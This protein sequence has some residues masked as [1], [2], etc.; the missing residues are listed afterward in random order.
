MSPARPPPASEAQPAWVLTLERKY[1]LAPWFTRALND[2]RQWK[3]WVR[4]MISTFACMVLMLAQPS[5]N[6]LGAAAFFCPLVSQMLPPYLA[7]SIYVFAMITLIIGLLFG[8]AWGNAAMAAALRARSPALYQRQMAAAQAGWVP[9]VSPI[10]Q[11]E[12]N[13]IHGDFLDPRSSAVYGV[14]IFVGGYFLGWLRATR[15]RLTLAAIFATIIMDLVCTIG[16]LF[17][18][19]QYLL[20]KELVVPAACFIAIALA[21]IVLILPQTLNHIILDGL[22][23][24]LLGP[25]ISIIQIQNQLLDGDASEAEGF[26][27]AVAGSGAGNG[28]AEGKST[29]NASGGLTDEKRWHELAEKTFNLRKK[30]VL[31]SMELSAQTGMLQLEI[32]RGQIGP[33]DLQ[34]VFNKVK[35]LGARVYGLTSFVLLVEEQNRSSERYKN[36]PLPH[37]AL[38][39]K[40]HIG[41]ITRYT[42]PEHS[43]ANLLPVLATCTS[44]LRQACTRSLNDLSSWFFLVNHTR[45]KRVPKD[46]APIAE[47]EE[48][49]AEVRRTL[50][51][52]R[53][54]RQFALI[55]QFRDSFDLETGELKSDLIQAHRY[56]TRELSR[57]CVLIANLISFAV[58][59]IELL[60][61]QL[62]IERR[63]PK[64]KIQWPNAFAKMLVK[65]ANDKNGGGNPVDMGLKDTNGVAGGDD[66]G[67]VEDE[68]EEESSIAGSSNAKKAKEK[69][70]KEKKEKKNKVYAKDPD[71]GPP[72]NTFQRFGRATS[73]FGKALTG[74]SGLFAFKHALV[75]VALYIP[76]VCPSSAWIYFTNRGLWGLI[77]AQT[78]MGVFTGEQIISFI[79]RMGATIGGA[80]I[81]MVV[82]Y[83]GSGRGNGNP[84][85]VG[86]ATMVFIA[87]T[88]FV[89]IVAPMAQSV[90]WIMLNVTTMFVV[91]YSWVDEHIEQ[92][93]NQGHGA[94]LAGRRALLVIIGFAAAFLAMLFP[95]PTSAKLVFRHRLAKNIADIGDLYGKVITGIEGELDARD[96]D[97]GRVDEVGRRER[98]KGSFM[99]ILARMMGMGADMEYAGAEIGFTG[100][101]PKKKYHALFRAQSSV[102]STI[103]LL[104]GCYSRME[105][106][107]CKRLAA[108]SDLMH[109]GFIADCLMLF[110]AIEHS[111]RTGNPLP[112]MIPIFERLALL[113]GSLQGPRAAGGVRGLGGVGGP[114]LLTG[115][116]A[117]GASGQAGVRKRDAPEG[118]G[119]SG[120]G[121]ESTEITTRVGGS[122]DDDVQNEKANVEHSAGVQTGGA[123]A[124]SL[125]ETDLETRNAKKVLEGT[126]TWDRCHEEQFAYFA[127]ANI[128]LVHLALGLND[129]YRIVR[130]LVG[131]K[132]LQGLDRA[133]ER[134]ARGDLGV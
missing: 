10:L 95:R 99:K 2:R 49:L 118:E 81:G 26:G 106:V 4:C 115:V 65:V 7:L 33:R 56:G 105:T 82:W 8:W 19:K 16:P 1:H 113:E 42:N 108:R 92:T 67:V 98:Y 87:P 14:F 131:E 11:F 119:S 132:E 77:M 80:V 62:D 47:R 134:W 59:L 86:A 111:L 124:T 83:V 15:P 123:D 117:P 53:E 120:S 25:A 46:A 17:P 128:A 63:N 39:T 41:R 68:Q 40:E 23:R 9:G 101:W 88:L 22:N 50:Q 85:G 20:A 29:D 38:R 48:N 55:D 129:M 130:D 72:R 112:P 73:T 64:S 107:W 121:D 70:E 54:S 51:E 74:P 91:G 60:E 31:A 12:S 78:G 45:W 103:A 27:G 75:S 93:A 32:T 58:T 126:I 30:H 5:L 71:A 133:S 37:S 76:A 66:E 52:F 100:P 61:L 79:I 97:W 3:N 127:S 28:T 110:S 6:A 114:R 57:C 104:S 125:D 36:D 44:P 69:K 116:R 35:D 89:R 96:E 102:V 24:K 109:P 34:K 21:S 43:F 90:F 18:M 13:I 94:A 122:V 84:Y